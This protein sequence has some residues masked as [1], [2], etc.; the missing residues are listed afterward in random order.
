MLD[1]VRTGRVRSRVNTYMEGG[2]VAPYY[3]ISTMKR[4]RESNK[5]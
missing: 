2:A 1:E 4:E 5:T 3:L